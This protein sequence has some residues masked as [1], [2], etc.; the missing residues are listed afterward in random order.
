M[1]NIGVHLTNAAIHKTNSV[2][3]ECLGGSKISLKILRTISNKLGRN[4][5]LLTFVLIL[6]MMLSKITKMMLK[7]TQIKSVRTSK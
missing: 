6:V 4:L 1:Q 3:A 5:N 2:H 7:H